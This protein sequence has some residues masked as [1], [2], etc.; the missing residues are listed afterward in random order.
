MKI[1]RSDIFFPGAIIQGLAKFYEEQNSDSLPTLLEELGVSEDQL[2]ADNFK[3]DGNQAL[4]FLRR[5]ENLNSETP[6]LKALDLFSWSSTGLVGLAALSSANLKDA[7]AVGLKYGH[8]CMHAIKVDINQK[9][10]TSL[11]MF[12]LLTD[13]EEINA[14]AIELI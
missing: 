6:V 13:F 5:M 12:S 7:V 11:I 14:R 8:V 3:F 9:A 4:T 2:W 1:N 10:D